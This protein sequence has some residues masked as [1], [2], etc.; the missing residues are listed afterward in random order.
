MKCTHLIVLWLPFSRK[1]WI[2]HGSY[3]LQGQLIKNMEVIINLLLISMHCDVQI[4]QELVCCMSES[5]R[6]SNQQPN[7][8]SVRVRV[9]WKLF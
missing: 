9:D 1:T 6:V 8:D 2:K 3:W 4:L 7:E 5:V